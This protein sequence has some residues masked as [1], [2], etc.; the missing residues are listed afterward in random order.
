M[1]RVLMCVLALGLV[2]AMSVPADACA[3]RHGANVAAA[4]DQIFGEDVAAG[5]LETDN[6]GVQA[7][8]HMVSV[9]DGNGNSWKHQQWTSAQQLY[10]WLVAHGKGNSKKIK[11][12]I[13]DF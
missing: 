12:D 13:E 10:D 4:L 6:E 7:G 3:Y 8:D 1:S 2:V 5:D 11:A 9:W